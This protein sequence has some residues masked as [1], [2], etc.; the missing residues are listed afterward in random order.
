MEK[1]L[2][3]IGYTVETAR[4]GV[5]AIEKINESAAFD[6]ILLDVQMP[7]MNGY[8]FMFEL[9]KEEKNRKIPV[10]VI[11]AYSE[12]EPILRHRGVRGYLVKPVRMEELLEK[13]KEFIGPPE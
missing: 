6:L 5:S 9:H 4:N 3:R 10:I 7:D 11:S 13:I 1:V 2:K 12:M 8:T